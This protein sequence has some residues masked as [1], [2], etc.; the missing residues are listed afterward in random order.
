[1][2][3]LILSFLS[4]VVAAGSIRADPTA[5]VDMS[6]FQE[7]SAQAEETT[8]KSQGAGP[9]DWPPQGVAVVGSLFFLFIIIYY[10]YYFIF[11][12]LWMWMKRHWEDE[13]GGEEERCSW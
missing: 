7:V 6:K 4:T 12:F 5:A 9:V 11:I 10:Y 8:A 13:R 1:M 2:K 3:V